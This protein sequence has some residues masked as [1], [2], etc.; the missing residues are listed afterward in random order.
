MPMRYPKHLRYLDAFGTLG[1]VSAVTYVLLPVEHRPADHLDS[2]WGNFS[3]EMI[4][5]WLSVRFIDWIIRSHE[6]FT[7]ARVRV[8]RNMRFLDK[9][10]LGLADFRRPYELVMFHRELKWVKDRLAARLKHLKPD[11]ASDVEQYFSKVDEILLLL[12]GLAELGPK[13]SFEIEEI[14]RYLDTLKELEKLRHMAEANILEETDEDD[15]M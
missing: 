4:G 5:I 2:L 13:D 8:V 11:E 12:P 6:S 7:K 3:T 9:L 14:E 15:G 1:I 10:L